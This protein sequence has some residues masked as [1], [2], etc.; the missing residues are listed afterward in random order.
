MLLIDLD[1]QG[2]ASLLCGVRNVNQLRETT[3][4]LLNRIIRGERLP[5]AESFLLRHKG[6]DLIPSNS[7]LF[8]LER[9]LANA[10]FRETKL[11]ELTEQFREAYEYILIDCMPNGGAAQI[12]AMLSADEL[13]IPTQAEVFSA[14]G[15]AQLSHHIALIQKNTGHPLKIAGVLIT[16]YD[17]R[18]SLTREVCEMLMDE[19]IEKISDEEL[20]SITRDYLLG[21]L[22]SIRLSDSAKGIHTVNYPLRGWSCLKTIFLRF[23][24]APCIFLDFPSASHYNKEDNTNP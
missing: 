24:T 4:S 11:R 6:V 12:N 21:S 1:G 7:Q 19:Y 3:A 16:M 8:A 15:L 10:D 5:E 23:E 9:N 20:A 14:V 13:V 17:R 2:H 22:C 18:T